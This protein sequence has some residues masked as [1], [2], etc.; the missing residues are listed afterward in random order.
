[1]SKLTDLLDTYVDGSITRDD[2]CRELIGFTFAPYP[3]RPG[4]LDGFARDAEAE[5]FWLGFPYENT[6][7]EVVSYRHQKKLTTED[8]R[9]ISRALRG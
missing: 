2:L 3:K 6:F 9:A 8:L 5:D 7:D 4:G 1:M